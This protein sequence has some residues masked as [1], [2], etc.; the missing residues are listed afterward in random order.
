MV[1][2]THKTAEDVF[3]AVQQLDPTEREKLSALLEQEKSGGWASP[4]IEQVWMEE[5]QR[6]IRML[7]SGEMETVSSEDALL[8]ARQRI[9]NLQQ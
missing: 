8:R 3:E 1:K 6:R 4:E 5:S 2:P 7:N 9:K